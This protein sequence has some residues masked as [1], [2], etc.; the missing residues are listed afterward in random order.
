MGVRIVTKSSR[1]TLLGLW[2]LDERR[3][4]QVG[5]EQRKNLPRYRENQLAQ[6]GKRGKKK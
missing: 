6:E 4:E 1:E 5:T 3:R 2:V